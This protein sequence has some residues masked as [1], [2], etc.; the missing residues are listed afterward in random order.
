MD[1]Y[2]IDATTSNYNANPAASGLQ[3]V[4]SVTLAAGAPAKRVFTLQPNA[5]SLVVYTPLPLTF[6]TE[7]LTTTASGGTATDITDVDASG[8]KLNKFAGTGAGGKVNYTVRVP[9]AD[10][11]TM[12]LRVKKTPDRG[13]VRVTVDGADAGT[14]DAGSTGY[15]FATVGLGD[16]ALTKGDHTVSLTLTGTSTGGWTIGADCLT[17]D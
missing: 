12:A 17:L 6:E 3:K 4:E 1:R 8:G 15:S 7:D 11:Y 5:V 9:G 16:R 10:T 2:L 13:I 14:V